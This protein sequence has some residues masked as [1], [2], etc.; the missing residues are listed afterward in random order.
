MKYI[1]ILIATLVAIILNI[2]LS[3]ILNRYHEVIVN[4]ENISSAEIIK[5]KEERRKEILNQIPV[6]KI[7]ET[8]H[9]VLMSNKSLRESRNSY[10]TKIIAESFTD[11]GRIL[12]PPRDTYILTKYPTQLGDMTTYVTPDP[13]DGKRHPAVI[14]ISGGYGGLSD[15]ED[16]FWREH[17]RDDDQSAS[18]F[19][20]AGLV[21]MLPSFRGE[22]KNPGRYEMF[23]GELDDIE[24]AFDWLSKLSY[25]DPERIYL[26]GHSTGGTRVLLASEYSTK[27]RG[28]F[29]LG[30]IPDLKAR[31]EGGEM[32]VR[33]PFKQTKKEFQLRSPARYIKSIK[34]PTWYF[35]GEEHYWQAFDN[36][37]KVAKKEKIPLFIYKIPN[38]DHFNIIA[39]LTEMIAEKILA[40]TGRKSNITFSDKDIAKISHE[41]TGR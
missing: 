22:D 27:F 11:S 19:R 1:L 15:S 24:A 6:I 18:A 31:V 39:P 32:S 21:V 14:W 38:G 23:Y 28:Y 5:V 17:D 37:E 20:K 12:T 40:D 30:G 35:E 41:L 33:I 29:S 36:I 8:G 34:N 25:V 4:K 3:S 9:M 26:A 16:F 13:K 10:S 7:P 2:T